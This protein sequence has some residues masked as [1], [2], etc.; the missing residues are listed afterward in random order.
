VNVNGTPPIAVDPVPPAPGPRPAA[1][2]TL[3]TL[4]V[5]FGTFGLLCR[6]TGL[7]MQMLIRTPQPN[8]VLDAF[9]NDPTLRA[10]TFVSA[11]TGTL[12]SLLLLMSSIGSLRLKSWARF[13][14]LCYATLAALLTVVGQ[15][16]AYTVLGPALRQAMR[17]AGA[18]E[19][20]PGWMGGPSGMVIGLVLGLWYPIL[21]FIYYNR[22]D[23]KQAF[24]VGLAR[25]DI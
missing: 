25:K 17:Q 20:S 7:V 8:P 18:A 24:D 16:F 5:I 10:W 19:A 9:R 11:I 22:R 2:T 23:V 4:G 14:M 1:V 13:G 3:A 12:V 21:I 15:I 6:P